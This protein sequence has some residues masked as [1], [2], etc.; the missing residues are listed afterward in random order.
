MRLSIEAPPGLIVVRLQG[1]PVF[2]RR[3]LRTEYRR[4]PEGRHGRSGNMSREVL[5]GLQ[6]PVWL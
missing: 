5:Y 1:R 3:R 6:I 2:R 4:R